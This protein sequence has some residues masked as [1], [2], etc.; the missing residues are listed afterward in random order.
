M[1]VFLQKTQSGSNGIWVL[2]MDGDRKPRLFLESRFELWHPD[3]SPDG[4]WMA[5]VSDES[6]TPEVYV[7]PY[8]GPGRENPNLDGRRIRADLDANGRELLYRAGTSETP[9]V[10]L[11]GDPLPVSVPARPAAP[12]LRGQGR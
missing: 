8:P 7:Q 11:R 12:A 4:R 10:F 5:Y 1:I 3:F 6:G 2:P 9:A